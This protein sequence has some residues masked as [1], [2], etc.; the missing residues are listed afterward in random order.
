MFYVPEWLRTGK[1]AD[2][3]TAIARLEALIEAGYA[4]YDAWNPKLDVKTYPRGLPSFDE[5][6][7]ALR[8]WL[9]DVNDPAARNVTFDQLVAAYL[10]QVRATVTFH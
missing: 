9:D 3:P 4:L 6:L 1:H 5:F 2:L 7:T 10:E 8:Y